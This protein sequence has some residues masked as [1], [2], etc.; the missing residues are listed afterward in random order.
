MVLGIEEQVFSLERQFKH[1]LLVHLLQSHGIACA[2]ERMIDLVSLLRSA[3]ILIPIWSVE[4][5]QVIEFIVYHPLPPSLLPATISSACDLLKRVQTEKR[6]LYKRYV[7]GMAANFNPWSLPPGAACTDPASRSQENSS[8]SMVREAAWDD[9]Q[10]QPGRL[11]EF[12][13]PPTRKK[14]RPDPNPPDHP[15]P[16]SPS[17]VPPLHPTPPL[18]QSSSHKTAPARR[19]HQ[20]YSSSD[21]EMSMEA[22]TPLTLP[23]SNTR[24]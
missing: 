16:P 13:P 1:T 23:T 14:A 10:H 19:S 6:A 7:T 4:G 9:S 18:R 11:D 5:D 2:Q 22:E 12:E 8:S 3:D 21:E 15:H 20:P 24:Q 17:P